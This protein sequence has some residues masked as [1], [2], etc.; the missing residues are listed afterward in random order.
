VVKVRLGLA[1]VVAS[2]GNPGR[3][4]VAITSIPPGPLSV[5]FGA[6]RITLV[7][8]SWIA[9]TK[10]IFVSGNCVGVDVIAEGP[11]ADVADVIILR[12]TSSP[13]GL[14]AS[15]ARH[16]R[17]LKPAGNRVPE[18]QALFTVVV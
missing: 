8:S 5:H 6:S 14:G 7:T 9:P 17:I 12:P 15:G 10:D 11:P 1:N 2:N 18:P 4:G 13:D 16:G 3:G